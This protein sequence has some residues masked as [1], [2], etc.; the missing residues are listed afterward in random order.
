MG[1]EAVAAAIERCDGQRDAFA[2]GGRQPSLAE[3][4]EQAEIS[5]QGRG[6]LRGK[7]EQVRNGTEL[8]ADLL[9]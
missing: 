1:G 9:Q 2:G 3:R 5:F 4:A 8:L 7:A 6:T